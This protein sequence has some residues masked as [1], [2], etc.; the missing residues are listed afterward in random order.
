IS[1]LNT[2]AANNNYEDLEASIN[3]PFDTELLKKVIQLKN[4]KVTD[5]LKYIILIGIGGSNLG[6]KAIY[7]A[8][9]GFYDILQPERFPKIIFLDTQDETVLAK[10]TQLIETL[11][12][13]EE[14]L[15]NA[16]SKSG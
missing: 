2:V 8:F 11:Q 4:K 16:I 1:H 5:K 6:T 9:Y 15:V 12:N 14:I 10:T 7:D 13:K 3:L